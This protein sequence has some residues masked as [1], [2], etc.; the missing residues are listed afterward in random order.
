[1][2]LQVKGNI[3]AALMRS[4]RGPSSFMLSNKT[5]ANTFSL[6]HLGI[7]MNPAASPYL[8]PHF[9]YIHVYIYIH[10]YL[11]IY[12]YVYTYIYIYLTAL[13]RRLCFNAPVFR[14]A[15]LKSPL[16]VD[17]AVTRRIVRSQKDWMQDCLA[18]VWLLFWDFSLLDRCPLRI[19]TSIHLYLY[20]FLN[21]SIYLYIYIYLYISI[22]PCLISLSLHTSTSLYLHIPI[23]LCLHICVS[24]YLYIPISISLSLYLYI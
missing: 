6:L 24:P 12:L 1:M 11:C 23:S 14:T 21:I 20:I 2:S 15:D 4:A 17:L 9:V 22:S 5:C 3:A 10:M 8:C 7:A 19:S 13:A 16:Q 18:V